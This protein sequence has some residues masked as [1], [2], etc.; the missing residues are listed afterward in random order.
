LDVHYAIYC[1]TFSIPCCLRAFTDL[2]LYVILANTGRRFCALLCGRAAG[3]RRA[4]AGLRFILYLP[5]HG[6]FYS[7]GAF[8]RP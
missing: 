2:L 7:D 3:G 5:L 6:V 1:R 4:A 8:C